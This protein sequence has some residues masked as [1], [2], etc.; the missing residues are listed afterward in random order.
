MHLLSASTQVLGGR[1]RRP[2]YWFESRSYYF[3]K[4]H[5]WLY[6]QLANVTWLAGFASWR[7]RRIVQGK[8]D[9]DPPNLLWDFV[10]FNFFGGERRSA[11]RQIP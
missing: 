8:P 1:Q 6:G 2:S 3:R 7:L 10:R 4:N 11:S 5:G 9:S